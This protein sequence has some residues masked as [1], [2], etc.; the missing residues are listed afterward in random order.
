MKLLGIDKPNS[1]VNEINV[2]KSDRKEVKYSASIDIEWIPYKGKYQHSKTKI[3]EVAF[4]TNWGERIVLHLSDY[5]KSKFPNPERALLIDSLYIFNQFDRTLGW[6]TTGIAVYDEKTGKRI[7]GTDSDFFI[8]HQRCLY[9]NLDSPF[10]IGYKGRHIALKKGSTKKHIDLFKVFGNKAIQNNVFEGKYT[11]PSLE[12]VSSALLG[13]SKYG[14]MNAG[15]INISDLPIKEQKKYVIRDAELVML[16]AQYKDCFVL[17]LMGKFSSYAEMDYYKVCNTDFSK[18]YENKYNKM[19]S[20]REITVE[21]TPKYKL[22]KQEYGGGHHTIPKKGFFI[23]SNIIELDVKGMYGNIIIKN[24]SS[25]DTLNCNCCEDDP[26]AQLDQNTIDLINEYLEG[27]KINRRVSR[28]WFCQK[29][30][31]A[32]PLILQGVLSDREK[33]QR[34]L[35]EEKSKPNPDK[36]LLDEYNMQQLAAK[37]FANVGYGLFGNE[38]FDYSNYKV[39]ECITA[40]GRRIH[41]QME[42]LAQ[43]DPFNFDIVFGFTDSIFVKINDKR[44][45]KSDIEQINQFIEYCKKE[46]GI[47]VEIKNVFVNS[48]YYGKMNYFVGWSGKQNEDLIIK[49][50]D[51]LARSNPLWVRRWFYR[52][53]T[54]IIKRPEKRFETIPNL[55]KEAVFELENVIS[56]SKE[57]IDKE[58]K[59]TQKLKFNP[60]HYKQS[61]RQGRLGR[62]LD[63]VQG[64]EIFWF[65]TISKDKDTNGNFSTTIPTSDN[66]NV[67]KYKETLLKKLEDTLTITGFDVEKI[68]SIV[69]L[70]PMANFE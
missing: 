44:H 70:K 43:Q 34:L 54:E 66:L 30:K 68:R 21:H 26:T 67:Q 2:I 35:K 6:Y 46:L 57:R 29:R 12:N 3:Y 38:F 41:K 28:I 62:L 25:F 1:Q 15:S 52:I 64:E 31:G 39:A 36:L 22:E 59:F 11:T 24:N 55:L 53:L 69:N 58:L 17:R 18:W 14:N 27:E 40:E 9:Y 33:Y 48:I 4:C 65:E 56:K 60:E 7:R 42:F 47:T 32:L 51:G 61:A 13:I 10:E 23:N 49:G 50:L 5:D 45:E 37:V 8:L 16:L 20:R 63:K 19:I